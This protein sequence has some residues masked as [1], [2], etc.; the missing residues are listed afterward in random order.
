MMGSLG[1]SFTV[2]AGNF[3]PFYGVLLLGLVAAVSIGLIAWYNSKR[4]PGWEN[5]DRPSFIPKLNLE[6]SES[7]PTPDETTDS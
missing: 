7:N 1:I 2:G 3:V 4:P 6:E 5:A